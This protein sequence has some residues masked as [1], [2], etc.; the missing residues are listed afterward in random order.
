MLKAY[1]AKIASAEAEEAVDYY[2]AQLPGLGYEFAFEMQQ[3]ID[4]IETHPLAWPPFSPNTRKCNFK[5]FPYGMLY[6]VLE[7]KIEIIAIM[8]LSQN[9]KSWRLASE[10]PT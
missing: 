3:V 8:N 5:R 6:R 10:R 7:T 1:I 9:P 4:C 2:N